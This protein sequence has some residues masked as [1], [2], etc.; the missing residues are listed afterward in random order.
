MIEKYFIYLNLFILFISSLMVILCKNPIHSVIYLILAFLS[1]SIVLLSFNVNF[2]SFLFL[3]IYIGAVSVLFLFVI[4]ML[5]IKLLLLKEQLLKYF[6]IGFLIGLTFFLEI[7]LLYNQY[8]GNTIL[9]L[10]VKLNSWIEITKVS[11]TIDIIGESL[12]S[13]YSDFFLLAGVSLLVSMLGVIMLTLNT[14]K[15]DK[16]QDPTNQINIKLKKCIKNFK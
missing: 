9:D 15:S 12:Y 8:L 6:P 2:L 14:K 16:F 11:L 5:N 7:R 13:Y 4:M 3:I 1:S 10:S